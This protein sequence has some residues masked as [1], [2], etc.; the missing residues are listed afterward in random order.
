MDPFKGNHNDTTKFLLP[1]MFPNFT[2]DELFS[3][4]FK[5][6]YIG[7]MDDEKFDDTLI[8]VYSEGSEPSIIDTNLKKLDSFETKDDIVYVFEIET[9]L[10]D[11]Y[12]KFISGRYSEFTEESKQKIL[13]FWDEDENSILHG[14]L[15]KTE[16]GKEKLVSVVD[17]EFKDKISR[18]LDTIGVEFWSPPYILKN[19]LYK[20]AE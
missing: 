20:G 5:E 9:D 2:H 12:S 6:A 13:N 15:Y 16:K 18:S 17:K 3:D 19:E 8:L 14:I 7:T 1:I 10:D 4:Y 11:E